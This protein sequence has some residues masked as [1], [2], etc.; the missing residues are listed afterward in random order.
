MSGKIIKRGRFIKTCSM[1]GLLLPFLP[2]RLSEASDTGTDNNFRLLDHP[3]HKRDFGDVRS[4]KVIF[5]CNCML[6]MNARM[7]RCANSFPS[8]FK[9]IIRFCMDNDLGMAQMPCP[10]LL[11]TGL[12]RDRDEPEVDYLKTALEMPVSRQRIRKL[13]EQVVFEMKEYRFQGFQMIAV[14]GNNGSPSCGVE[15]TSFPDPDQRF[16]PGRGVFIQ[17]LQALMKLAEIEVPFKGVDD[18]EPDE[19]LAW[20]GNTVKQQ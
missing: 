20:L 14:I 3:R 9:P 8:S 7:H 4:K 12:G 5:L 18:E 16:G 6:N 13:A 11:V 19:A 10:E 1:G 17:E 2:C 15:R